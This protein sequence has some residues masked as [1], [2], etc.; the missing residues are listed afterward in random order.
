MPR[1]EQVKSWV[2][3]QTKAELV[4]EAERRDISQSQLANQYIERGLRQD[5]EEDVSAETRASR[6]LQDIIDQGL[7]EFGRLAQDIRDMQARSGAHSVATFE[8]IKDDYPETTI[9]EAFVTG[10]DRLRD[11]PD[12]D[13]VAET[14]TT[15]DDVD[16]ESG[17]FWDDKD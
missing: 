8:L 1:T 7:D 11:D 9:R 17:G 15:T 10:R 2:S 14:R 4:A 3:E 12:P 5:K 13:D 6:Q 16:D